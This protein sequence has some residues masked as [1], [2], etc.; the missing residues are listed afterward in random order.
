MK[1]KKNY[2]ALFF[3]IIAMSITQSARSSDASKVALEL[4]FTAT[5]VPANG[6]VNPYGVAI[7]PVNFSSGGK[8]SPGDTLVSNFNN[9]AGLQGTGSTIVNISSNGK[10][11]EFFQGPAGLGL[12]TALGTLQKGFVIVGN[13][14]TTDGT[15]ATISSGSLL[16]ID[17]NGKLVQ[18]IES[19]TLL[20][21]PWDLAIQD[22]GSQALLFVSNV[23][24]GAVTR[25]QLSVTD[26]G[27]TVQSMVQI[28]SGYLHRC[29]PAA[30]VV[31]PTGLAY[32]RNNDVLYVASTGDN[33]IFAINKAS[34]RKNDS[35]K[36]RQI[37]NDP[38]HLR[39]PLGLVLAP[40]GHLLTSNGDAVNAD[41]AHPSE[42]IEFTKNG[43]FVN[44]FSVDST[45][46]SAFGIAIGT[47][48]NELRFEAVDDTTNMLQVYRVK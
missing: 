2:A 44:Q 20:N 26:T 7:V 42:I 9:K 27:V 16:V 8:L 15:C 30:L 3:L 43:Q 6:D 5:T 17:K 32:D 29:D 46:G 39:G 14:P 22:S 37:Y 21:G 11:S 23:L 38:G 1:S 25:I 28:A 13:V 36:G 47:V 48:K 35:G 19:A 33:I 10:T 12:T 40:N 41:T 31:G 24:S 18:T 34:C 45:Q 4:K